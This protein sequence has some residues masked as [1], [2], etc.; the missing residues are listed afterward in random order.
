[1]EFGDLEYQR[2]MSAWGTPLPTWGGAS[3]VSAPASQQAAVQRSAGEGDGEFHRLA[4]EG[5]NMVTGSQPGPGLRE[6][7][8]MQRRQ[9]GTA[10]STTGLSPASSG[11]YNT[12]ENQPA[13]SPLTHPYPLTGMPVPAPGPAWG[14]PVPAPAPAAGKQAPGKTAPAAKGKAPRRPKRHPH[15][16]IHFEGVPSVEQLGHGARAWLRPY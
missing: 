3:P 10:I 6:P 12:H 7:S 14:K 11:R 13:V 5:R 9:L 1:M 2:G 4:V 15:Y 8:E 16:P